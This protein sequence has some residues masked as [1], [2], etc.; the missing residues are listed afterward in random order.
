M[1]SQIDMKK[2]DY[3]F[4]PVLLSV[5]LFCSGCDRRALEVEEGTYEVAFILDGGGAGTTR[6]TTVI[7]ETYLREWCLYIVDGSGTVFD[8]VAVTGSSDATG[9]YPAGDYKA[10]AVVN[11]GM[12]EASFGTEDEIKNCRRFLEDESSALS[13]FGSCSFSVPEDNVCSIPISRL[14]SKVEIDK[15]RTDFSQ[16]PDLYDASFVLDRIYLINAAGESRLEDSDTFIPGVWY[17]KSGYVSDKADALLCDASG[18][19]ITSAS[20]YSTPHYFYC[21]QNNC[22]SD[23]HGQTWSPRHTRLVLECTVAGKKT[24]YPVDIISEGGRL[25]RNCRYL[26]SELVITDIGADTPDGPIEGSL[27]YRFSIVVIPWNETFVISEEL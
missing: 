20:P 19:T 8:A 9:N 23:V 14:V 27:P 16:Y 15:V 24:Y 18:S 3:P 26:I 22:T 2:R 6:S 13:M 1:A 5:L 4:L 25:E 12:S 21:Y 11:C 10:Y 17:N 7:D